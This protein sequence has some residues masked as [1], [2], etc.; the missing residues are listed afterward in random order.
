MK[1]FLIAAGCLT[2]GVSFISCGGA[3]GDDPGESYMPDMYYARA[4]E[5]YNYNMVEGEFDSL[6]RRGITY[7]QLPVAGTVARGEMNSYH[8]TND[9]TGLRTA[10]TSLVNP[11]QENTYNA[12]EAERLYLVNCGICHGDKLDG[13]GPIVVSEAYPAVPPSLADDRAKTQWNDGHYFHVITFGK[14]SMGSYASQLRPEQRWQ[15]IR[16][17]RTRQGLATTGG[18]QQQISGTADSTKNVQGANLPAE[19]VQNQG[20]TR[21][22]RLLTPTNRRNTSSN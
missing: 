12:K 6:K 18:Q 17:I 9:S 5:A 4:Y 2:L 21:A 14:G 19:G 22:N 20:D 3:Q 11:I 7:T 16:Y 13:Q 15:V 10:E 8:L 1:K